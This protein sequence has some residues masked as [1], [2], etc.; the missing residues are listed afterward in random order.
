MAHKVR[1]H[2]ARF[3]ARTRPNKKSRKHPA[4]S[5]RDKEIYL[6]TK[7]KEVAGG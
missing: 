2:V 7:E 4:Q 1:K 6:K 5:M 3:F